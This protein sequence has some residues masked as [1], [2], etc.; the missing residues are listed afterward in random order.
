[1]EKYLEAQLEE[2][3]QIL[4]EQESGAHK[5]KR[6]RRETPN[7]WESTWGRMLL[8]A[9]LLEPT[10]FT[11]K[12][13]RRRFRV[14]YPLFADVIMPLCREHGILRTERERIPLE[15]KVLAALRMLGRD[16][17]SDSISELSMMGES[18]CNSVFK[19]FLKQFADALYPIY[20]RPPEGD[21]LL[22]VME[23][24]RRLGFPG[25]VGSVDCTHV[26]WMMCAKDDKW[27]ASGKEGYPTLSFEAVVSH[28]RYCYHCSC[29]FYGSYNDITISKNDKF[30]IEIL[31]GKYRDTPFV[32]YDKGGVPT[33]CRG[34]YLICDNGYPKF[35]I[36]MCPFKQ[37][38][39]RP[40]ILW[41][42]WGESVR[43]DVECFFGILKA[44][45]WFLR[46]AVRYHSAETVQ[47]AF[48]C[49][50]ILHNMLLAYDGYLDDDDDG[51][52][53]F[54]E[55]L[56]PDLEDIDALYE[57]NAI[58]NNAADA[59]RYQLPALP[60][61][62]IDMRAL[63][64]HIN[65]LKP[66]FN[67]R[68]AVDFHILRSAL[69]T[70][71]SHQ[72]NI[73]DLQWPRN[74]SADAKK[75]FKISDIDRRAQD[76][77]LLALYHKPSPLVR[78]DGQGIGDGLFSNIS[79]K[80]NDLICYFVGELISTDERK[81]RERAGKGGYMVEWRSG[82]VL[83][84]YRMMRQG[85]CLAS[86]ANSPLNVSNSEDVNQIVTENCTITRDY[87]R[88]QIALRCIAPHGIAPHTEILWRYGTSYQFRLQH[89]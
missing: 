15:F 75:F 65:R 63:P 2:I 53:R 12:K 84:C 38:T 30:I 62:I 79:Y 39:S 5:I 52:V 14:P 71:F 19:K 3:I 64:M 50:A 87:T 43:K 6:T 35:A 45:F 40:E 46:N 85:K 56:H 27:L 74:M 88:N 10:S 34:G 68:P 32:L 18:T 42:E 8:D 28:S 78:R 7:Y 37:P 11:A 21:E 48:R 83:D 29:A 72:Y 47:D 49:C 80:C 60:S 1:M 25:A 51:G 36:F 41:S 26:K 13:F 82:E 59:E 61:N 4:M 44:R 54:W 70:H 23:R 76:Q 9:S 17:C 73:G 16:S 57:E 31:T 67:Y 81:I 55:R 77:L 20:V 66:G 89:E 24:Y 86:Y 69:V 22:R 58:P 33:L